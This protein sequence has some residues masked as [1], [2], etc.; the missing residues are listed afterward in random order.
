MV[1]EAAILDRHDGLD[2]V[3][4]DGGERH[5]APLLAS[6]GGERGEERRV[7]LDGVERRLAADD[8]DGLQP[9]A[10]GPAV[11]GVGTRRPGRVSAPA[12]A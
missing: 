4:G 9:A 1:V 5:V 6:F 3:R 2:H 11:E 12:A 10:A 8:L 7:E